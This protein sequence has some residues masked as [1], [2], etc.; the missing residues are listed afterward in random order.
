MNVS[1]IHG[2][3]IALHHRTNRGDCARHTESVGAWLRKNAECLLRG[4]PDD[5]IAVGIAPTPAEAS[6]LLDQFQEDMDR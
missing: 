1:E 6:A 5:W 4:V 3:Y 2:W